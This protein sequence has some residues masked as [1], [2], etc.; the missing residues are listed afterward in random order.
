MFLLR[1]NLPLAWAGWRDEFDYLPGPLQRPW[2]HLGD[3]ASAFTGSSL[4]VNGNFLTVNGG[5]PSY[6]WQPF[7]PNWGLDF[8]IY[9]PV[10][11]LA[12]QGF[13][14]YFTDS[15]SRIG[16][17]FQNVVGVRL[18]YAPAAGGNQVMVSHFQN[19]M[20]WDGDAATWAS[21]VPFGGSGNVWLRVWC[22]RDEW[23]RIWVNGTYVGSCMIKPSFKL[24]PDRR[25]V[26]FLNTALANAQMLWLDH[27]DRPSSIPPKQVWSEVFYDDFNR[28][29]GEAG[30]GWT[31]IGQNAA[32]RSGEWSTI[33]TTDG[34]RG[35]IRDTGITSGM[36][37]VEA[38]A[39]TFSAPKTGADSSL[40]LCSNAAGTEG[41]SANIFAGSLYIAR[42]SGSLTNPSM[43]DFDQL[44]SGVSVSPGDKVA[45]CV[46]QGI[47][48]IEING[49]PRLYTGNAH[50]VIPPTNTFAGLRVSRASF[51]DSNSWNDVR[52]FSGI[53]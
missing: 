32:L 51:A 36:V 50:R 3:G 31:Q 43:I 49:T 15:W 48:W 35:L 6:Q 16:A 26:R 52:I 1:R 25:C 22:E 19:V 34:S 38:T 20:S 4:L 14:T 10:E 45:F 44:T 46:Y 29:D 11:G 30:N 21:P 27:Y 17:S 53:G 23:V 5:G 9:W 41:L 13:S 37:R 42:Y 33:G 7:T 47:A 40:I 18:M 24:G 8:E 28:P 39:G 12:S 2:V